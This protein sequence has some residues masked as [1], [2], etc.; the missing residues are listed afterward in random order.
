MHFRTHEELIRFLR[1]KPVEPERYVEQPEE[2]KEKEA[3]DG[4][5]LQTD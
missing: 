3:D 5:V 2:S 1:T 4:E